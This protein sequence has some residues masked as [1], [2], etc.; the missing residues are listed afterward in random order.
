MQAGE[1]VVGIL[2]AAQG[3]RLLFFV[4]IPQRADQPG[5]PAVRLPQNTSVEG[6]PAVVLSRAADTEFTPQGIGQGLAVQALENSLHQGP[7][8]RVDVLL[9]QKTILGIRAV[10]AAVEVFHVHNDHGAAENVVGK[11]AVAAVL[12]RHTVP[13]G[14]LL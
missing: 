14:L 12:Q 2:P 1:A 9:T 13:G 8:I 4:D 5:S 11:E 7:V 3:L 6:L 10:P